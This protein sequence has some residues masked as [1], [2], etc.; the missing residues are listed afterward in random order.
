MKTKSIISVFLFWLMSSHVNAAS[1]GNRTIKSIGCHVHDK[2]CYVTLDKEVSTTN[3]SSNSIRWYS[4]DANGKEILSLL[5]SASMANK[6]V[7]FNLDG[8]CVGTYP[9]FNYL[10]VVIE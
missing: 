7:N 1:T 9:K 5:M 6:Q 2:T 10:N 3:C 8:Q 4:N